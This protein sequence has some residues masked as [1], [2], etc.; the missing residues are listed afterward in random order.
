M[1]AEFGSLLVG[2]FPR[3]YLVVFLPS[4]TSYGLWRIVVPAVEGDKGSAALLPDV[5]A[6]PINGQV[7]VF[8][9]EDDAD[10]MSQLR[11]ERAAKLIVEGEHT[12]AEI[13]QMVG[14]SAPAYFTR[15]F[16]KHFGTTPGK[17]GR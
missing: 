17:Y 12:V 5:C 6:N 7:T 3:F 10:M 16:K 9:V 2:N 1:F 4:G 8:L 11:T 15:C 13:S 14:F